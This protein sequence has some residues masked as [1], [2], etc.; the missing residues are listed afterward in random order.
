MTNGA[1]TRLLELLPL[2]DVGASETHDEFIGDGYRF[3]LQSSERMPQV[4]DDAIVLTVTSPPYWN[5]IDYDIHA[6]N[7]NGAWWIDDDNGIAT[8][9]ATAKALS[10]RT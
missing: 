9:T 3:Y 10:M 5:A 6:A 1:T 2:T 4:A 7:G 8:Q